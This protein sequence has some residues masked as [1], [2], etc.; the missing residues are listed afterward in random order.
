MVTEKKHCYKKSKKLRTNITEPN[1]PADNSLAEINMKW[2]LLNPTNYCVFF[3]VKIQFFENTTCSFK[4][5]NL[6]FTDSQ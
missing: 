2:F 3:I 5:P 4:W 6:R 1:E